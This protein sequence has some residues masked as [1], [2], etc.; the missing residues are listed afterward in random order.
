VQAVLRLL[1]GVHAQYDCGAAS[2]GLHYA[3]SSGGGARGIERER[4]SG[5]A[6]WRE[7]NRERWWL[8]EKW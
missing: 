1:H 3:K 6:R 8:F 2:P 4:Q 5:T 7:A